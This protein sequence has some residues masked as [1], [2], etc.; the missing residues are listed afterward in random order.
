MCRRFL[1]I[2]AK[3]ITGN[4]VFLNTSESPSKIYKYDFDTN[5][6][7]FLFS[8]PGQSL[9]IVLTNTKLWTVCS[10]I[11]Y[12][13]NITL[14]PFTAELNRS[15]AVSFTTKG[16]GIYN[17]TTLLGGN[18]QID[19]LDITTTTPIKTML[20]PFVN[21]TYGVTGDILYK[22]STNSIYV[23][24]SYTRI[25]EYLFDGTLL[26]SKDTGIISLF[27]MFIHNNNLYVI[28]GSTGSVYLVNPETLDLTFVKI[29]PG[30]RGSA[31][32]EPFING[33]AQALDF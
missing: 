13:Y 26:R 27:G 11:L 33:S 28:G 16:L 9:D 18:L 8:L 12:E 24:H 22:K 30:L 4:T 29:I 5:T 2:P 14:N 23:T 21:P 10:G 1:F 15:F 20:F 17:D 19:K 7:E 32:G 6:I 25:D 3:G 31:S